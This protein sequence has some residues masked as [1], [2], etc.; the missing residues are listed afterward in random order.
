MIEKP[1]E[2]SLSYEGSDEEEELQMIPVF[3]N[4]NNVNVVNDY[5]SEDSEDDTKINNDNFFDQDINDHVKAI[6]QTIFNPKVVRTM[7]N[8]QAFY[9][10]NSNKIVNKLQ[11]K[12]V[13]SKNKFSGKSGYG[14][15]R[16]QA[17]T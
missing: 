16:H 12:K 7:K 8:L 1:V 4:N 15:Q 5:D 9:S 3:N 13:P 11:K 6:P 17:C 2:V 14:N 10:N